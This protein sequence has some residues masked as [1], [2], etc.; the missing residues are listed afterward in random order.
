MYEQN[1]LSFAGAPFHPSIFPLHIAGGLGN[2]ELIPRSLGPHIGLSVSQLAPTTQPVSGQSIRMRLRS[3]RVNA[4]RPRPLVQAQQ[5][6]GKFRRH[7]GVWA[8]GDAESGNNARIDI[9]LAQAYE[10]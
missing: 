2:S 8:S 9:D 1:K 3:L 5:V 4:L 10:E 6:R 7:F